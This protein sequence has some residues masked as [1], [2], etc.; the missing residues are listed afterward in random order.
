MR[1]QEKPKVLSSIISNL[2]V[3]PSHKERFAFINKLKGHYK[4]QLDWFS[5]GENTFLE[6]KWDGLVDYK[7]SIAIENSSYDNY[8]T[9]KLSDCFLA[10]AYPFYS[11]CSNISDFFDERSLIIINVKDF[12][13]AIDTIDTAIRENVYEQNLLY[14]AESRRLVLEKYHF[15]AALTDILQRQQK[16]QSKVTKTM[17]PESYFRT[18]KVERVIKTTVKKIV[19]KN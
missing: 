5:K 11:G 9:E 8:F 19:G 13:Q 7:Y 16:Q 18:G 15:L 6:D 14:I 10:Y 17:R 4:D 12:K 2:T 1:Y 3:L